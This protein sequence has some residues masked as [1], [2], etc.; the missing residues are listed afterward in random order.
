MFIRM[1]WYAVNL[2]LYVAFLLSNNDKWSFNNNNK[3]KLTECF[4]HIACN[5]CT[6]CMM[7]IL[8][9]FLV[10]MRIISNYGFYI[11]FYSII[12]KRVISHSTL[13][14][15]FLSYT[16]AIFTKVYF[17]VNQH[18][19]FSMDS[20]LFLALKLSLIG[21]RFPWLYE[22]LKQS[23]LLLLSSRNETTLQ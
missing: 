10:W 19:K 12:Y 9:F 2:V 11:K 21:D 6:F 23:S 8:V 4:R 13:R 22:A 18:Y 3:R 20:F 1:D 7:C 17:C 5:F 16:F 15:D 14:Y